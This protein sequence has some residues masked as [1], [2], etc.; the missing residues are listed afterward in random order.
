MFV[1]ASKSRA[2]VSAVSAVSAL[3]RE[4]WERIA[5]R[6]G[7]NQLATLIGVCKETKEAVYDTLCS[8]EQ[9]SA[10]CDEQGDLPSMFCNREQVHAFCS[11]ALLG[12]STFLTGG[13]GSGKSFVTRRVVQSVISQGSTNNVL[14]VAPTGAAARVASTP[15]KRAETIHA[16]FNISNLSRLETDPPYK[17]SSSSYGS[18]MSPEGGEISLDDPDEKTADGKYPMPTARLAPHILERLR[19]IEL[20]VIDEISMVP[21][22]LFTLIEKTLRFVHENNEPFGAVAVLCVGDFCQLPPVLTSQESIDRNA[23]LGGPWAFQSKSWTLSSFALREIV[24]QKDKTFAAVL[25]RIRV[26]RATWSDTSWLNRLSFRPTPPTLSLFSSNTAC[27][28]RNAQELAVLMAKEDIPSVTFESRQSIVKLLTN[29]PWSVEGVPLTAPGMPTVSFPASSSVTLCTGA[30][31]RATKNIY[32]PWSPGSA[33]G[34]VERI[35]MVANGQRGTVISIIGGTNG[36]V[37]VAWDGLQKGDEAEEIVIRMSRKSKRQ[38]FKLDG[39]FVYACV[40]FMPLELAWAVTVHS[41]QGSSVL[42]AVDVNHRVM[43]KDENDKWVPQAGGSYVALSRAT[44]ASNLKMLRRFHPN[45]A[46]LDPSVKRFMAS[47]GLL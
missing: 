8:S 27:E 26:G 31:V 14:V 13:A 42:D 12:K 15:N 25:N 47:E 38:R 19:S 6:C 5:I 46:V 2:S 17:Y 39:K 3:P 11:V 32:Q 24:R 37:T 21:N 22:E 44:D 40:L 20:L 23:R 9:P 35:L 1:S 43:T 45:D 18:G 16:A 36:S 30:R 10:I 41:S 34:E 33:G 7:H 4:L 28:E 29:N